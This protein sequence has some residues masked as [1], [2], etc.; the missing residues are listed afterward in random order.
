MNY[1]LFGGEPYVGKSET[2]ERLFQALISKGFNAINKQLLHNNVDF[3]ACLEG[4]GQNGKA[5]RIL[6]SSAADAS[7][8]IQGF[9]TYCKTYNQYDFVISA[10]RDDGDQE[11]ANFLKIMNITPSDSVHEIPMGKITKSGAQYAT[12]LQWY[13]DTIDALSLAILANAPFFV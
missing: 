4:T 8:V 10:I 11:R 13:R 6:V 3:Y 2:I 9:K 7:G 5:I 12:A 1:L